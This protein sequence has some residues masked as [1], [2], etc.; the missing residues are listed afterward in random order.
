MAVTRLV[1]PEPE[2]PKIAVV[3]PG[4]ASNETPRKTR[5]IFSS[6]RLSDDDREPEPSS[7]NGNARPPRTVTS[8]FS[9]SSGGTR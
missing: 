9:T 7:P 8:A 3:S 1:L 4:R 2:G 6:L 5:T